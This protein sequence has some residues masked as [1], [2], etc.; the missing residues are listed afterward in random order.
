MCYAQVLR[1]G[2]GKNDSEIYTAYP[3]FVQLTIFGAILFTV[4]EA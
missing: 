3:F 1:A 4:F 2:K